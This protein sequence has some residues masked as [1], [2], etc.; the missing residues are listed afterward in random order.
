VIDMVNKSL[1]DMAYNIID[2][3]TEPTKEVVDAISDAE[4]V[5]H[6]RVI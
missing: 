5:M 6:V 1:G 3:E 4:G 2:I